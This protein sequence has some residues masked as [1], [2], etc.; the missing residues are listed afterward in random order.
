MSAIKRPGRPPL[1]ASST[2]PSASV[3]LKVS[4]A[5]YD[6]ATQLAKQGRESIQE[7]I[8]RGLHRLLTDE[9]GA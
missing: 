5:D 1:D 3:H 7:V 4:A 8:R 9:R 6:R 2:E